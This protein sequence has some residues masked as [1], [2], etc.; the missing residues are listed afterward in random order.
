MIQESLDSSL[1]EDRVVGDVFR[2]HYNDGTVDWWDWGGME[3]HVRTMVKLPAYICGKV[4]DP[5]DNLGE[6]EGEGGPQLV[7]PVSNEL[8]FRSIAMDEEQDFFF[9][10]EVCNTG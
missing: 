3:E 5:M 2:C 4:T 6:G 8:E 7:A 9:P 10:L 1:P